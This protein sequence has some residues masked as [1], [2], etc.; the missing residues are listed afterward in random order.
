MR[1]V[2]VVLLLVTSLAGAE[3]PVP[4]KK[5]VRELSLE[6]L[7]DTPISVAS[8][9]QA[10]TARETPGVVTA[11]TREEIH[12]SGARDLLE[13]LQLIP[14]FSFH[15]DVE[16]VVGAGFRGMWGH[17]GKVLLIVD[18]IELNELLYST[19]PFGGHVPVQLIER[20]EVIRGP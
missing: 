18:G 3:E 2:L 15:S 5:D 8:K 12:A 13:V 9:A 4:K 14:G 20:V 10:R 19:N 7:L 17:E 16:G 11:M 1:F 6:E